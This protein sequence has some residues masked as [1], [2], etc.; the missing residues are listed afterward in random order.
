MLSALSKEFEVKIVTETF[1]E[2]VRRS[3]EQSN[4][5]RLGWSEARQHTADHRSLTTSARHFA[6]CTPHSNPIR[7]SLRSS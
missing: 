3:E 6:P 5:Q 7:G 1:G 2:E 4:E